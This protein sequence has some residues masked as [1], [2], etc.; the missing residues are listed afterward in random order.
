MV[1]MNAVPIMHACKHMSDS[2]VKQE[3]MDSLTVGMGKLHVAH[4]SVEMAMQPSNN[5]KKKNYSRVR[6]G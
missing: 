3:T 5:M 6:T 2:Q 1:E 4:G